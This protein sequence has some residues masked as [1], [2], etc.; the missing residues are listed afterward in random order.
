MAPSKWS[1]KKVNRKKRRQLAC[2][3]PMSSIENEVQQPPVMTLR[4]SVF[5]FPFVVLLFSCT[6]QGA[7]F[8]DLTYTDNGTSI[9]ITGYTG[10]GGALEIPDSIDGKPVTE[11]GERAFLGCN[12]LTSATIPD[13]VT[14]IGDRAFE[15]CFRMVSVVIPDGLRRIGERAF[16]SCSA[17]TSVA[18]PEGILT[19][20]E[21]AFYFCSGLDAIEVAASNPNY[22]SVNGVLFNKAQTE[23]LAYPGGRV[24]SYAIPDSV[25]NIGDA[26]FAG[27]SALTSVEIPTKVTTIGGSAF[28][29][30]SEL[31]SVVIP[32]SVT[33]IG[34]SA[35]S[36][37]TALE[38]AYFRGNAPTM[39]LF[40]FHSVA[41][42]FTVYVR[43]GA[44]GFTIPQWY[45][46]TC[47]EWVNL[48]SPRLLNIG[49]RTIKAG[50][51]VT[52][53]VL[54]EDEDGDLLEYSAQ[55]SL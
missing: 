22:S 50:E 25:T 40:V 36:W 2:L 53:Q 1:F 20:G 37:C 4:S 44:S 18:I 32:S 19:I 9:T 3:F 17:L 11:I 47:A 51:T 23:L 24:G 33:S 54:A 7:Q 12:E 14:V 8:G 48:H 42:G 35:F 30:C 29:G 6:L 31:T 43:S 10:V 5:L 52:F 21:R 46:Y 49:N 15:A 38:R 34:F 41:S 26:A 39:G 28:W 16:A 55:G 45:D 13:S 27:S